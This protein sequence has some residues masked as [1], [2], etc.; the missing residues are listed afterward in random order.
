[1][2]CS[3]NLIHNLMGFKTFS[4]V[5]S[6]HVLIHFLLLIWGQLT[7][8]AGLAN[9]PQ[10]PACPEGSQDISEP[11]EIYNIIPSE[12][13]GSTCGTLTSWTCPENLQSYSTYDCQAG[14]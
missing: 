10:P 3:N 1:M 5:F 12:R 14:K 4:N 6:I 13:I 9:Q 11:Y 8:T 2:L 7:V